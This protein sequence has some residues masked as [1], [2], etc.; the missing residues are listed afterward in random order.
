MKYILN[1]VYNIKHM[2]SNRVIGTCET[3]EEANQKAHIRGF[4][5]FAQDEKHEDALKTEPMAYEKDGKVVGTTMLC[6]ILY[7][8]LEASL[9]DSSA[10]TTSDSADEVVAAAT[11]SE[12]V[13][14]S[15]IFAPGV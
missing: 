3:I 6:A 10:V 2:L 12:A 4:G 8:D 11:E 5:D 15:D 9:V 14:T 7:S 1:Q 13:K